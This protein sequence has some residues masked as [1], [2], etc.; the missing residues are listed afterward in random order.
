MKKSEVLK[1]LKKLRPVF[2][3]FPE[4]M[5]ALDKLES[6]TPDLVE[7]REAKALNWESKFPLP[8]EMQERTSGFAIFADVP[9]VETRDLEH[10]E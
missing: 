5:T 10:G 1:I 2:D 4:A 3:Q 9:V 8:D 7:I 6:L